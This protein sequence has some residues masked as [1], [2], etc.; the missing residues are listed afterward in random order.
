MI[1]N[2][3]TYVVQQLVSNPDSVQVTVTPSGN[4]DVIEIT[5]NEEDRGKVIGKEGYT[6]KAIRMM[7]NAVTPPDKKVTIDIAK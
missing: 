3:V 4:T 5:V 6:I 2:L 7:V 1:K